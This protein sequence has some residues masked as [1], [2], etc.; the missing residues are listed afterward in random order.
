M[1]GLIKRVRDAWHSGI[2]GR[3]RAR[4][5]DIITRL[6]RMDVI[7]S[8]LFEKAVEVTPQTELAFLFDRYNSDKGSVFRDNVH[9]Y[10]EAYTQLFLPIRHSVKSVFECGILKGA[11]LRAW[12]DYFDN[13]WIIGADILPESLFTEWRIHTGLMDQMSTESINQFFSALKPQYPDQFDVII[14]DG[15]HIY[16]ATTTLFTEAFKHLNNGGIYVIEDMTEDCFPKYQEFF[17]PYTDTN[18]ASVEYRVLGG[19]TQKVN[20]AGD[21]DFNDTL[22]I[23][24]K[25]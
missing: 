7:L 2:Y 22:V 24:T 17:K 1:F 23:I 20:E 11:S 12:R 6:D 19:R 25:K 8:Y 13:A 15:C 18:Q 9:R 16:E 3:M 10:S 5:N 21:I 14:D 4:S